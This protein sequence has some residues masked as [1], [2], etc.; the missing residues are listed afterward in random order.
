[1][2]NRDG[3]TGRGLHRSS[4]RV[5][6]APPLYCLFDLI[7]LSLWGDMH[8]LSQILHILAIPWMK[9]LVLTNPRVPDSEIFAQFGRAFLGH[10]I[11]LLDWT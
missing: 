2:E 4:R 3:E 6:T 10:R 11:L 9:C 7:M 8:D 5:C 1:M